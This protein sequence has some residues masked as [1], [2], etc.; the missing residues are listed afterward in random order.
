VASGVSSTIFNV[1][2]L[3]SLGMIFAIFSATVPLSALQDIFAGVAPPAGSLSIGLFID[4][5]HSAF[6]AMGVIILIAAIPAWQTGSKPKE[7]I[8]YRGGTSPE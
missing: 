2:S 4:A 7:T 6:I 5:M 8:I 1:G 3:L